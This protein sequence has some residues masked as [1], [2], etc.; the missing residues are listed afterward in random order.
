MRAF[1]IIIEAAK[2][3]YEEMLFFFLTGAILFVP[4]VA[5][6][7]RHTRV[8]RHARRHPRIHR[9]ARSFST[10][11]RWRRALRLDSKTSRPGPIVSDSIWDRA[12]SGK[13]TWRSSRSPR[14]AARGPRPGPSGWGTCSDE[15]V[16]GDGHRSNE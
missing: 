12:G 1:R 7:G 3:Y 14:A 13:R 4:V 15:P 16:G 11:S 9:P 8:A 5:L 10:V 6:L 2:A